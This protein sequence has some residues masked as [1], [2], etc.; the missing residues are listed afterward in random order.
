M[1]PGQGPAL[2]CAPGHDSI[3]DSSIIK[4]HCPKSGVMDKQHIKTEIWGIWGWGL[5]IG[6][7]LLDGSVLRGTPQQNVSWERSAEAL[8]KH[9]FVDRRGADCQ[10][11]LIYRGVQQNVSRERSAERTPSEPSH[12]F[13]GSL[14]FQGH[15]E[16]YLRMEIRVLQLIL[17]RIS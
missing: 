16:R 7:I 4:S 12:S 2:K 5:L 17:I 9:H 6:N 10:Q 14:R 8:G 1:N 13:G 15:D 11:I 3:K